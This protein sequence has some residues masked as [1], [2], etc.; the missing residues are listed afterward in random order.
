MSVA[1]ALPTLVRAYVLQNDTLKTKAA[2]Q[3]FLVLWKVADPTSP[4]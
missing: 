4:S 1:F 3:D 2:C